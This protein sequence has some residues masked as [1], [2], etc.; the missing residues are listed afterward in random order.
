MKLN[1]ILSYGELCK[2]LG[3]KAQ[4]GIKI[5]RQINDLQ[6]SYDI[7]VIADEGK[8][9]KYIIHEIYSEE[10]RQ[11]I[12]N[13]NAPLQQLK[14]EAKLFEAAIK[15]STHNLIL[16]KT[17]LLKLFSEINDNFSFSFNWENLKLIN[18]E[19]V[20]MSGISKIVYKILEQW[21][22]RKIESMNNRAIFF[23]RD[24]FRLYKRINI[25]NG[26]YVIKKV[27]VPI[28]SSLE[29]Q[30]QIIWSEEV[31]KLNK[32]YVDKTGKLLWMPEEVWRD[33]EKGVNERIKKY[34]YDSLKK[35]MSLSPPN[36][37]YMINELRKLYS[38][39]DNLSEIQEKAQ[40][41]VLSTT[42]LDDYSLEQKKNFIKYNM[43]DNPPCWFRNLIYHGGND[44]N[45][46]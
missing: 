23:K 25:G 1:Q 42:Q 9:N 31:S 39:I 13:L 4:S 26:N 33:F 37:E 19:F 12:K 34:G 6:Q 22:M 3:V 14:F 36:K 16:S 45:N 10:M 2:E 40:E 46:N 17:E 32:K 29:Q 18:E 44:E 8:R 7:E 15:S 24:C 21:T 43:V 28:D 35:V 11:F 41:K 20:Y 38:Q 5:Q 27:N 30:C